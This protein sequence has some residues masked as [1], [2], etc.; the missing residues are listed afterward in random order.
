MTMI[1]LNGLAT[2]IDCRT[3][4]DLVHHLNL[5]GKRFAIECNAQL[6]PKS[7]FAEHV[8]AQDDQIEIIHAVGGG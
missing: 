5:M 3:L 2:E 4:A 7:R 8:I 1:Y 6:V